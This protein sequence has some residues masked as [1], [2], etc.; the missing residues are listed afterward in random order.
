MTT[1]DDAKLQ[2]IA[3][4]VELPEECIKWFKAQGVNSVNGMA[5]ACT[6]EAEVMT[7]CMEPMRSANIEAAKKLGNV[8]KSQRFLDFGTR[9]V[10]MRT[11]AVGVRINRR[12]W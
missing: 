6:T 5:M 11:Q 3:E 7:V 9:R 2:R 8:A 10:S 4:E 1:F 12:R